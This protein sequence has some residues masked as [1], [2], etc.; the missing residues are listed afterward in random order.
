MSCKKY[1][2]YAF[3]THND[4]TL[5]ESQ[6]LRSISRTWGIYPMHGLVS[7]PFTFSQFALLSVSS[8]SC[9]LIQSTMF[10]T[11]QY[12]S[13]FQNTHTPMLPVNLG[14]G[15]RA[16]H[17]K[18]WLQFL[19]DLIFYLSLQANKSFMCVSLNE[20]SGTF[21]K[22]PASFVSCCLFFLCE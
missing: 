14:V 21:F 5:S 17:P 4:A 1:L 8:K 20:R 3:E 7:I 12:E 2:N 9:N 11:N 22:S 19:M 6:T 10:L 16:F 13:F 18:R 15:S